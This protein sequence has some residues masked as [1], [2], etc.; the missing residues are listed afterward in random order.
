MLYLQEAPFWLK[1]VGES[2]GV[3]WRWNS[4]AFNS[5]RCNLSSWSCILSARIP[6]GTK[7]LYFSVHT[8]T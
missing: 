8:G 6:R 2:M 1:T 4:L 5:M 3:S 7:A